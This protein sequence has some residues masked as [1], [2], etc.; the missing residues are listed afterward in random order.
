M[1]VFIVSRGEDCQGSEV[2]KVFSS[3]KKAEQFISS[4]FGDFVKLS[5]GFYRKSCDYIQIV[6]HEVE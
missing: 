4:K 3:M 5:E 6:Q 2:L 1:Q